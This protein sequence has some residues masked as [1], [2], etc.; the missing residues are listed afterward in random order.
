[1]KEY[2]TKNVQERGKV[3]KRILIHWV[4]QGVII[5]VKEDRRRGGRRL[6]SQINLLEVLICRELSRFHLPVFDLRILVSSLREFNFW[7]ALSKEIKKHGQVPYLFFPA[8]PFGSDQTPGITVG[9]LDREPF[10]KDRLAGQDAG[11][12][13]NLPKLVVEAGGLGE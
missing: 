3:A 12:V 11:I 9:Y 13:V 1:M 10:L 6:F 7:R 5:P 2:T 8:S 4:E